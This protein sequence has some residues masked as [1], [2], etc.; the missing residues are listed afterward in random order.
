MG[1]KLD[2]YLENLNSSL[3]LDKNLYIVDSYGDGRREKC[4]KVKM[5]RFLKFENFQ[6]S[7][8]VVGSFVSYSD[9]DVLILY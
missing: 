5:K 3:E 6:K 4:E 9:V 1:E 8:F 2:N 7:L